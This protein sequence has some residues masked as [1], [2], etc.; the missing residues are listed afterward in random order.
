MWLACVVVAPGVF[1]AVARRVCVYVRQVVNTSRFT[2]LARSRRVF[3]GSEPGALVHCRLCQC[4]A[5]SVLLPVTRTLPSVLSS[6]CS[7]VGGCSHNLFLSLCLAL[8]V[9]P[10]AI[11]RFSNAFAAE[12]E[13]VDDD[14]DDED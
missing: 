7:S 1:V 6:G 14:D 12:E 8:C 5:M 4:V 3:R 10:R 11:V 13:D 2:G 9:V